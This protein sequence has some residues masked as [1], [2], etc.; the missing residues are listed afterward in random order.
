MQPGNPGCFCF[1]LCPDNTDF[2][3]QGKK[4]SCAQQHRCVPCAIPLRYQES[5]APQDL[6]H[7]PSFCQLIYQL[8][9]VP[10]LLG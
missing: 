4:F 8:I 1:Y 5:S 9:Q 2:I 10:G 3:D 7:L 6:F